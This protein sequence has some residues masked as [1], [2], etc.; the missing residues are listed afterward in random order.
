MSENDF[1]YLVHDEQFINYCLQRNAA[2]VQYWEERLRQDPMLAREAAALKPLVI[3][4]AAASQQQE[5]RQQWQLLQQQLGS[6]TV[7]TPRKKTIAWYRIPAAAAVLALL[8]WGVYLLT[9]PAPLPTPTA[10][11]TTTQDIPAGGNKA[12]LTLANGSR[13][14]LDDTAEGTVAS[15]G[16]VSIHKNST[17]QLTYTITSNNQ[18]TDTGY[19]TI[20][21][22]KGGQYRVNLPDGSRVWLNAATSLTFPAAFGAGRRTVSLNGEAYFEVAAMPNAQP[23]TVK[24]NDFTI[25]VLGTQFNIMAYADEKNSRTTL[26]T[27]AVRVTKGDVGKVLQPGQEAITGSG[28]QVRDADTEAAVAWKNGMT[29][30]SD[31]DIHSIMR[32]IARWYDVDIVY[33]GEIPQRQF[34]GK[35]PRNANVSKVLKILELSN[36]HFTIDGRKIIVTP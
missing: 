17:G 30:F 16:G 31:A 3:A 34:T 8:L 1:S 33:Q 19:N 22:P 5:A 32:Q 24:A 27:G 23:F 18:S 25:D 21:T 9:R 10:V 26:L 2:D 12:T 4:L 35:I 28:I 15:Q 20:Q 11:N 14:V 7:P 6:A 29:V 13:I 36:I